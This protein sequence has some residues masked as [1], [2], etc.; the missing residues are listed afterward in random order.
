MAA[1]SALTQTDIKRALAYSTISQVG[2]MFLALGVGAW[3]AAIFHFANHAFFKALLFLAAGAI[4]NSVHHEQNMF[5]MGG[6]RKQTPFVFWVFLI[7]ASSLASLPLVTSGF[8]S[9]DL[10]LWYT[11]ASP[12]GSFWLWL[13]GAVGAVITALYSFRMVFL[14]FY[15]EP[16]ITTHYRPGPAI[17]IPLLILAILSVV[18]GFI[19]MPEALSDAQFFSKFI[20]LA[21]PAA[22]IVSNHAPEMILILLVGAATVGGVIAAYAGY[23][24]DP[25]LPT[26]VTQ[27]KLG[28]G[29]FRLF[30]EGWGFDRI[31]FR[32]LVD[33][34][35]R[36]ARAGK[37]D[38][39]DLV[40]DLIAL[41]AERLNQLLS[42]LQNGNVR[43]YATGI[44]FGAI[45][46]LAILVFT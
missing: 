33:P 1:C 8:Y 26:A 36:A 46:T 18:S 5:K 28:A 37:S 20:Q 31:Y 40:Y 14:V 4:I 11:W 17:K 30:Y 43:S 34:F 22:Q 29:A 16:K 23:I 15:G 12:K 27:D 13:P 6:L 21:L 44:A 9:K 32:F 35:V 19:Q 25:N 2:Y 10:I 7:G 24:K 45:V 38:V 3:S 42:L 39:I 41:V